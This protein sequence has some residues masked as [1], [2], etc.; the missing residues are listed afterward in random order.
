[1]K[2]KALE[3][4]DYKPIKHLE[5]SDLGSI[6]IIAGANGSGKTRL[7]QAIVET[8]QG[9]PQMS[10]ELE[11]TR[12]EERLKLQANNLK[13]TQGQQ[14]QILNEYM[15]GR[16]F[17]RGRYVGS[18]VQIDSS[19]NIQ[20][21]TYQQVQWQVSDPDDQDTP[22]NF[23]YQNFTSRWQDF[24]NYIH[25]KVGAYR[26]KIADETINNPSLKGKDTL[27]KFPHPLD[28]YKVIFEQLLPGKHLMDIDPA[29]VS[30]F[31]YIDND[32]S[33]LPFESLSS[34]EQEVVKVVFDIVRKDIRHSIII[35]DEP[36][37]HL[38]PTLA[39]KLIETLK[40]IGKH[41]NQFIFLTHSANLI[42]TY[43]ATGNV[44]FIDNAQTGSNQAHRLS[45]LSHSHSQVV[46]LIGENLGL[47]SVG[48][49][50][51][52]VEG[53]SSSIDRLTYQAIATKHLPEAKVVHVG[54]V[55]NIISL[56]AVEKQI[57]NSIFGVNL[58]MIRDR[59]GLSDTQ[60]KNLETSGKLKVLPKRHIEN[61][62]L[63]ADLL[64]KVTERLCLNSTNP[65]LSKKY[66]EDELLKIAEKSV[67]YNLLQNTKEFILT[68]NQLSV[69]T[70][71][72]VDKK[73]SKDIE[74]EMQDGIAASL[75]LLSSSLE[76]K[77][78]STWMIAEEKRLQ[79]ALKTN[80]WQSE[81]QGKQMFNILCGSVLKDDPIRVRQAYT[82][83]ALEEKS[84]VFDGIIKIVKSFK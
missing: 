28:K 71:K 24:I 18:L 25:Q 7:K 83:I 76:Q 4:D 47:F 84:T 78:I 20:T 61:Y 65:L 43:F 64:F 14:N 74:K 1:M 69:P 59:D 58:Y 13:V 10:L 37:L 57:R 77:K 49:K 39:F 45:E 12:D 42:S 15:N 73:D 38:H 75:T 67:N 68:N 53:E 62:F 19:R 50:I 82:D 16:R 66:I 35:V 55:D 46:D 34:G 32:G 63:D 44:Y 41:T 23:Y 51:I 5:L 22:S 40:T 80:K 21:T 9:T 2:I 79:D 31:R 54:S 27:K 29:N 26:G 70:V 52:F 48:K 36:E 33:E 60:I 56:N 30:P 81:F 8:L 11:A 72:D 3:I 17:G 6:V